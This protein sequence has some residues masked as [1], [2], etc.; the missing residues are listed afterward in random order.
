MSIKN[1]IWIAGSLICFFGGIGLTEATDKD[2]FALVGTLLGGIGFAALYMA[3]EIADQIKRDM[4][5]KD[6]EV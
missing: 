5:K 4:A 2:V 3:R 1:Y 6:S